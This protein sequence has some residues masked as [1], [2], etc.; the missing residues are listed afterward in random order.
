MGDESVEYSHCF[1]KNNCG[2][3][4]SDYY[5][6]MN[7]DY[8]VRNINSV[9]KSGLI[10]R[11]WVDDEI[12]FYSESTFYG[13]ICCFSPIDCN[14]ESIQKVMNRFNTVQREIGL[15][16]CRASG[17]FETFVVDEIKDTESNLRYRALNESPDAFN[18][19]YKMFN[20][21]A[22]RIQ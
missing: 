15:I 18:D 8:D 13:D 3:L 10:M 16:D 22:D 14:E 5:R 2:F 6:A 9:G 1:G 20:E 7:G 12:D 17:Y 4:L 21:L 19:G 11:G